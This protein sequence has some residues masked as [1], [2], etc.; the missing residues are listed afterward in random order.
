MMREESADD[1]QAKSGFDFAVDRGESVPRVMLCAV[2][3]LEPTPR[4][5]DLRMLLEEA[6]LRSTPNGVNSPFSSQGWWHSLG[7][8][9]KPG[10]GSEHEQPGWRRSGPRHG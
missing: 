4:D 7:G 5:A 6:L 8:R 2:F 10:R 9:G 1:S 3:V